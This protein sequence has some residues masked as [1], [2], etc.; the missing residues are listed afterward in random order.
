MIPEYTPT[1]SQCGRWHGVARRAV[2]RYDALVES[3][4]ASARL[5]ARQRDADTALL[6]SLQ[7]VTCDELHHERR[8]WHGSD[9]PCPILVRLAARLEE[10]I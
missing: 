10:G 2:E 9:E 5:A 7:P 8:D 6:R 4:R 1:C 3:A